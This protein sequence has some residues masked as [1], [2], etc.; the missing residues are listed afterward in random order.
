[1]RLEML[2]M[3]R[4]QPPH[5][6]TPSQ[7]SS[8]LIMALMT[9]SSLWQLFQ[10]LGSLNLLYSIFHSDSITQPVQ[11]VLLNDLSLRTKRKEK[12]LERDRIIK[13]NYCYK[14]VL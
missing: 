3:K 7:G 6:P 12:Q 9:A 11:N 1:M 14:C 4:L 8:N 10:R 13:L 2:L 5:P